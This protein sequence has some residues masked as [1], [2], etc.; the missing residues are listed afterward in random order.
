MEWQALAYA[1][2]CATGVV[3]PDLE[4]EELDPER[5]GLDRAQ[6][7]GDRGL[8]LQHVLRAQAFGIERGGDALQHCSRRH[9]GDEGIKRI[10]SANLRQE[11]WSRAGS[12]VQYR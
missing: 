12:A 2:D 4:A 3:I 9:I 11:D 5:V 1:V 8:E 10:K 6:V 7:S